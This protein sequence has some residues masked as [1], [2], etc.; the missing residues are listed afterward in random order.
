M[1]GG[2]SWPITR[3]RRGASAAGGLGGRVWGG[4]GAGD[5]VVDRRVLHRVDVGG[6]LWP[7]HQVRLGGLAGGDLRGQL[8]GGGRVVGGDLQFH[9]GELRR[10]R[11]G[12]GHVTLDGRDNGRLGARGD[13][14]ERQRGRQTGQGDGP[15]EGGRGPQPPPPA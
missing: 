6:V 10:E 5:L 9:V 12:A 11:P 14:I 7:D 13:R 8:V 1:S 4:G 2:V 15:D 3:C